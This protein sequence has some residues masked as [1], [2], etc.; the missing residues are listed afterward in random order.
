[1]ALAT[2]LDTLYETTPA[3]FTDVQYPNPSLEF[4][5]AV[6]SY[7]ERL[8]TLIDHLRDGRLLGANEFALKTLVRGYLI[9]GEDGEIVERPQHMWLRVAVGIHGAENWNRVV[10]TYNA[11]SLGYATHATPTLFNAGT[12]NQQG[13]SCFLLALKDG[14]CAVGVSKWE[15]R[16]CPPG[17][18]ARSSENHSP[19]GTIF[20]T[21]ANERERRRKAAVFM[22]KC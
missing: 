7:G 18:M 19:S 3:A 2:T 4:T 9:R 5:M 8:N 22:S 13:A 11:M 16:C 1:M 20:N 14:E 10:E 17:R 21:H 12:K 15:R 6:I